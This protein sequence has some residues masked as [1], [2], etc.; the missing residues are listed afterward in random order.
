MVNGEYS[1]RES[2]VERRPLVTI[3]VSR[4]T[5]KLTRVAEPMRVLFA[6][7]QGKPC[8]RTIIKFVQPAQLNFF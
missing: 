1:E 2:S 7:A 3:H 8:N 6:F 4:L 5:E